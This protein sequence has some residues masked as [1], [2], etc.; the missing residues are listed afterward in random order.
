MKTTFLIY[1]H[2][3]VFF[4]VTQA[5]AQSLREPYEYPIK[6]GMEVWKSFKSHSQMVE[7]C[8][9]PT[10]LLKNMATSTLI[11]A[12]LDYPLL[13]DMTA[14][15]SL[16]EGFEQVQQNSNAL[17][18]L[19]TR[20][21]T[22]SECLIYYKNQSID[23]VKLAQSPSIQGTLAFKMMALELL[24]AEKSILQ[25]ITKNDKDLL[26][27]NTLLKLSEKKSNPDIYGLFGC[28]T[29]LLLLAR[30][31]DNINYAPFEREIVENKKLKFFLEK[32]MFLDTSSPTIIEENSKVYLL[33]H[34]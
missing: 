5:Q 28:S 32:A 21:D 14:F 23:S 8:K 33:K 7:A 9:I 31:L 17:S 15:N 10:D 27:K 2:F 6:P 11:S 26:I 13:M 22:P 25:K 16:Q 3:L 24:L 1:L 34:N 4:L 20:S 18:E 29:T 19:L 30:L 12:Y